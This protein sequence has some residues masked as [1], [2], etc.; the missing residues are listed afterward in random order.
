MQASLSGLWNQKSY[1]VSSSSLN[2]GVGE[3]DCQN[4]WSKLADLYHGQLWGRSLVQIGP[5]SPPCSVSV[6]RV[7]QP[8]SRSIGWLAFRLPVS[9][10]MRSVR[11]TRLNE[12]QGQLQLLCSW[13]MHGAQVRDV[14]VPQANGKRGWLAPAEDMCW[15][16]IMSSRMLVRNEQAKE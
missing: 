9:A 16:V 12:R 10:D 2:D 13:R 1:S 6:H 7:G 3:E 4:H 11:S 5:D 14:D 8:T 15:P